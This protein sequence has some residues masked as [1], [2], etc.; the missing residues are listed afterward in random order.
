MD[1]I[2]FKK[3]NT[4]AQLPTRAHAGDTGFDLYSDADQILE[5]G[6]TKLITTGLQ[7]AD[8]VT[9][10]TTGLKVPNYTTYEANSIFMK[11]E[12][13]SG[14]ACNGIFPI[15]GIIDSSYRGEIK[16]IMHNSSKITHT[17]RQGDR[18]AQVVF[19]QVVNQPHQIIV[20]ETDTVV[21]TQRAD[22]GFGSSGR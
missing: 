9:V 10:V 12:G 3:L 13:R 20:A 2:L 5:P 16:C 4:N 17:F 22:G 19:Y 15:G 6:E 8:F 7:L 14:L 1:T 11:I 21:E 18:I